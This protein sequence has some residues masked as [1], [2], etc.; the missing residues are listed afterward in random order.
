MKTNKIPQPDYQK[1]KVANCIAVGGMI[2]FGKS[3]LVDALSNTFPNA[4][5]VQEMDE[6]DQLTNM[7]LDLMYKRGDDDLYGPLFQTYFIITRFKRYKENCN[8]VNLNIFDRTVYEDW[9]FAKENI[10]SPSVFEFY[11]SLWNKFSKEIM[12]DVGVPKLYVILDGDWELFKERIYQRGRQSEI[13]N[14]E[15]NKE[16]FKHLLSKY[17]NYLVGICKNFGI[18]YVVVN[19]NLPTKKQVEIIKKVLNDNN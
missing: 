4:T 15:K 6:N 16:Y 13:D 9:L 17:K 18:N 2:A 11:D 1:V 8:S 19:A 3:T 7:L 14:F 5:P 12:Y 10:T